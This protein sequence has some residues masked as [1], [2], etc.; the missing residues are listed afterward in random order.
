LNFIGKI[1]PSLSKGHH[2][3]LVGVK[4]FTK[5]TEV[6]PLKNKTHKDLIEFIIE[7]IICRFGISQ[8]LS[9]DQVTSFVSSQIRVC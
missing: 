2:F 4:Y 5:W 7:H 1:Q 6:V 9:T 3:V 8:T